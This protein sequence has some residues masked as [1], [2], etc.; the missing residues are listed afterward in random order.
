MLRPLEASLVAAPSPT[1]D[2]ERERTY[3][4]A[5]AIDAQLHRMAEDLREIVEK[6]NGRNTA[7]G[8]EDPVV[9]ISLLLEA[10]A[11]ALQWVDRTTAAVQ[12]QAEDVARMQQADIDG[13]FTRSQ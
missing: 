7:D 2:V 10:H 4:L 3:R 13:G 11:D 1:S 9:Q 5:E 8:E 12:R 6:L